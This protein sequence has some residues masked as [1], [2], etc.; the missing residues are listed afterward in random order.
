[1]SGLQMKVGKCRKA[2]LYSY[3]IEIAK[4]LGER[5][6]IRNVSSALK[7]IDTIRKQ[8]L[9]GGVLAEIFFAVA[10]RLDD[11][12]THDELNIVQEF[13]FNIPMPASLPL[14]QIS[15]LV[16]IRGRGRIL[17][18]RHIWIAEESQGLQNT[19][20]ESSC[21]LVSNKELVCLASTAAV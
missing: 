13:F 18:R 10:L 8:Y 3:H 1:M 9:R 17:Q 19:F 6:Y 21:P 7:K 4:G 12:N 16:K 5:E 20:F 11:V 2:L 15:R 14:I